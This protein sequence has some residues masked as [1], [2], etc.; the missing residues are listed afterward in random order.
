MHCMFVCI[1]WRQERKNTQ[2]ET[3]NALRHKNVLCRKLILYIAIAA[4]LAISSSACAAD[5]EQVGKLLASDGAAY[6]R[7]GTSVDIDGNIAIVGTDEAGSAYLFDV[8]SGEELFKLTDDDD[9]PDDDFGFSVAIDG[10]IGV[11][12]AHSKGESAGAAYLFEVTTGL[13]LAKLTASDTAPS[14]HF[15]LSVAIDGNLIIIGAPQEAAGPQYPDG[16]QAPSP[17]F[18]PHGRSTRNATPMPRRKSAGSRANKV[19]PPRA[20]VRR[21]M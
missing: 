5:W 2:R 19:S 20:K 13:Q 15:G 12:G 7:F 16:D 1:A 4:A 11:V 6:Q 10:D 9:E 8:T 18:V 17:A 14:D 21:W 3:D